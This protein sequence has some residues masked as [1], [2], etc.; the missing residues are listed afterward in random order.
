MSTAFRPSCTS[1]HSG[2]SQRWT[3]PVSRSSRRL[4]ACE[5]CWT[6]GFG[7]NAKVTPRRSRQRVRSGGAFANV[8]F[9]VSLPRQRSSSPQSCR[10]CL[11]SAQ[12]LGM[13]SA[14]LF[15]VSF[16]LGS[17]RSRTTPPM[18]TTTEVRTASVKWRTDSG[19]VRVLEGKATASVARGKAP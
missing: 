12:T 11:R 5:G 14:L 17:R 3:M 16:F 1:S 8:H 19:T 9:S 15:V 13:T 10:W 18:R 2:S 7:K 6:T 4:I